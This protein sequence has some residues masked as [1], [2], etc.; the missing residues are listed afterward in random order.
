MLCGTCSSGLSKYASPRSLGSLWGPRRAPRAPTGVSEEGK[1][2]ESPGL[3]GGAALVPSPERSRPE[4]P[5]SWRE[6]GHG[7]FVHS[8]ADTCCQPAPVAVGLA[9][10]LKRL[11]VTQ[12]SLQLQFGYLSCRALG[13]LLI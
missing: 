1:C 12:A 7:P 10:V 11:G 4:G 5:R 2:G 6:K 13:E 9:P 3:R 8:L